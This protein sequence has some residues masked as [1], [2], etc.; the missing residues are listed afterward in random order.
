MTKKKRKAVKKASSGK[1]PATLMNGADAEKTHASFP[2]VGIGASAGGFEA[3]SQLLQQL[4][5]NAGMA[6]II[7]QHLHPAH[8]SA[9]AELLSRSAK[10]PVVEA[11]DGMEVEANHA[12]VIPPNADLEIFHGRLHLIPR[13]EHAPHLPIDHFFRSLAVEQGTKAIGVILSGTASDGVIGL[14]TIKAEGG[15]TFSQDEASAKYDGM[16]HSAIASGCVDFILPPVEIAMELARIANHPYIQWEQLEP[17]ETA[18]APDD[19]LDKI[20]LLLR[21]LTGI[22]FTYYKSTTIQ[23]RIK[24]RMVLHRIDKTSHYVKYL[25]QH[26]DEVYALFQDFLINVTDFFRDPETFDVLKEKILPQL[27]GTPHRSNA[28]RIWVPGCS[29]GEEVY[30]IAMVLL[31]YLDHATPHPPI[32]IFATDINDQAI[33]KARQ[34]VY[35]PS[36]VDHVSQERLLRFFT[37]LENG[38]QVKKPVRDLCIFARQNVFKDPPFS[39]IDLISCRNLLIY[40]SPVLQKR[41]LSVF[42]YALTADG[43]LFL[44]SAETT[45]EQTALFNHI[46]KKHKIYMKK[47]VAK[48]LQLDFSAPTATDAQALRPGSEFKKLE[49]WRGPDLQQITD[50]LIMKKYAPAAVVINEQLQILQFRGHTGRYL[51]PS[52]G[53]ASLNL[54]KMARESLLLYLRGLVKQSMDDHTFVRKDNIPFTV[55]GKDSYLRIEVTPLQHPSATERYYLV[56]FEEQHLPVKPGEQK[57]SEKRDRTEKEKQIEAL[58]QELAATKEYLQSVIEQQEVSNE[59]LRSANEEIQSSNEELQSINEELETA[60][61]ELQSTNEELATVNEELENRNTELNRLNNDHTNFTNSL[62]IA[63][64]TVDSSLII[65]SFTSQASDLLK[66]VPTDIGRSIS[67]IKLKFKLPNLEQLIMNCIEKITTTETDIQ[68]E[69]GHWY[70][71]RIRPYL[72]TDNRIDGAV[73]AFLDINDVKSSLDE[74]VSA[75]EYADAVIYAM[76]HPLLV[77]DKDL[78]VISASNAYYETFKVSAQQILGNLIYRLGNGEWAIPQL[79]EKL[80]NTVSRGEAFDDFAV[81][82]EFE[83][84]GLLSAKVS[85]RPLSRRKGQESLALMQIEI[86]RES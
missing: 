62:N 74:A 34:G 11:K 47:S 82:H 30:S 10:V 83:N 65:R 79:R 60:K 37:P 85:G 16:P 6:Y 24:R 68:D 3:C 53:E 14:K 2:I 71:M 41:I 7:I 73:I 78:R 33:E 17:A 52:P 75:R 51:E 28:V 84:V 42:H 56:A 57:P 66:V 69:Q 12:Y 35:A 20:F 80:T 76:R 8:E 55:D 45:G 49:D 44:G 19:F 39:K 18:T 26:D 5:P 31:E 15:I 59:E 64:I 67:D 21:K 38:Y 54:L 46:D 63:F 43:V 9:L 40:L 32:Q 1:L 70:S 4:P 48:P 77:V 22:D 25:Q 23:R 86:A 50:R 27:L 36:I 13:K 81:Q 72:T 61:E 29:T 58:S